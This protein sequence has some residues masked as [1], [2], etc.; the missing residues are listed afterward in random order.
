MAWC[1]RSSACSSAGTNSALLALNAFSNAL[2]SRGTSSGTKCCIAV[3]SNR[4]S[5]NTRALPTGANINAD[6]LKFGSRRSMSSSV[7]PSRTNIS[8]ATALR[9]ASSAVSRSRNRVWRTESPVSSNAGYTVTSIPP[10]SVL[11]DSGSDPKSHRVDTLA[12][13]VEGSLRVAEDNAASARPSS[14]LCSFSVSRPSAMGLPASSTTRRFILRCFGRSSCGQA[15]A[16][17]LTP[18]IRRSCSPSCSANGS[19]EA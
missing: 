16:S 10:F 8:R 11:T 7:L 12:A 3:A 6:D 18:V 19:F 2:L 1:S 4:S 17:I 13:S 14:S 9:V 15:S 5:S